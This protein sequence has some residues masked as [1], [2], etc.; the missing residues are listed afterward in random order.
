MDRRRDASLR[1]VRGDGISNERLEQLKEARRKAKVRATCTF[2]SCSMQ[3]KEAWCAP[4]VWC[5]VRMWLAR[6]CSEGVVCSAHAVGKALRVAAVAHAADNLVG[7]CW[8]LP[9]SRVLF[10]SHAHIHVARHTF[11]SHHPPPT[12]CTYA[13]TALRARCRRA[14]DQQPT[15]MSPHRP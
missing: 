12:H 1:E 6:L 11:L 4:R 8:L 5:A 15:E 13:A 2:A 3:P 7:A 10:T 9:Y 14:R